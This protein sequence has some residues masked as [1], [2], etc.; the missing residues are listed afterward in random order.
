MVYI[1]EKAV[2]SVNREDLLCLF[3]VACVKDMDFFFFLR[4]R[5][6]KK[7]FSTACIKQ[8]D[9]LRGN[10]NSPDSISPVYNWC[11]IL[12]L[13]GSIFGVREGAI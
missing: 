9:P 8:E 2:A 7:M 10:G 1:P 13:A 5:V 3:N 11:P 4:G 12:L 6:G